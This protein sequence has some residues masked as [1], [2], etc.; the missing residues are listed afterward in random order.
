MEGAAAAGA[1]M[2]ADDALPA[3]GAAVG[4]AVPSTSEG[5]ASSSAPEA[6]M[7]VAEAAGVAIV[8]APSNVDAEIAGS[9]SD[10]GPLQGFVAGGHP[11]SGQH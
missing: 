8:A 6:T 2:V 11:A 4:A 9:N 1:A 10:S 7:L 3:V 5:L